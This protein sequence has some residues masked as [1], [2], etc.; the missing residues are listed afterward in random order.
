[1]IEKRT[2]LALEARE[3][4][5]GALPDGVEEDRRDVLGFGVTRVRITNRA[6]ADLLCKP[7]GDYVTLE[8]GRLLRREDNAFA[9]GARALADEL[10]AMLR[11][12]SGDSVLVAGLGNPAITPD[13]VGHLT[14]ESTL[15]TRHLRAQPRGPFSAFRSVAVLEPGVLGTT[16]LESADVVRAVAGEA[17][18]AAVIAVDALASRRAERVCTTVQLSDTGIVPGSGVGGGRTALDRAALGVPVIALGVPTVVDA[19]TLASDLAEEAG[20]SLDADALRRASGGLIVTP[21][22]IDARV[23]DISRLLGYGINLALHEGLA[24]SDLDMLLG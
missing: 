2:D 15:A 13:A 12:G 6:G 10:R 24:V 9:D 22:D 4:L 8:L 5:S 3:G 19:A 1:M 7:I 11:L 20:A 17:K 16:G 23:R 18:P 21:R 14:A